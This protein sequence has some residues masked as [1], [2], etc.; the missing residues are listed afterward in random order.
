M[1]TFCETSTHQDDCREACFVLFVGP[2]NPRT[3]EGP[4]NKTPTKKGKTILAEA[5]FGCGLKGFSS[6]VLVGRFEGVLLFVEAHVTVILQH[7]RAASDP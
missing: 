2:T 1:I 4:T 7:I 5:K 3:R 6:C